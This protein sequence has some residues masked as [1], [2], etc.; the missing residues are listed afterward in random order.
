M[1]K[2][3]LYQKTTEDLALARTQ[4]KRRRSGFIVVVITAILLGLIWKGGGMDLPVFVF[5]AIST[6]ILWCNKP[7]AKISLDE[8][9]ESE[10]LFSLNM[11]LSEK[12]ESIYRLNQKVSDLYGDL[13]PDKED[14]M[15]GKKEILSLDKEILGIYQEIFS[16]NET[17]ETGKDPLMTQDFQR[18]MDEVLSLES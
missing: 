2:T 3:N 10:V 4:E 17:L 14:F 15:R 11:Q 8:V 18:L 12:V 6:L 16:I 9:A 1:K 5:G 7:W 13:P